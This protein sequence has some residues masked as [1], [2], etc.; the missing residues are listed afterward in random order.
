VTVSSNAVD[1]IPIGASF[2]SSSHVSRKSIKV[3]PIRR[4]NHG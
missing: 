1:A 3:L 2:G 4:I